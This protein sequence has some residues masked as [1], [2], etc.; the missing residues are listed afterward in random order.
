M[1][2]LIPRWMFILT[3]KWADYFKN[4]WLERGGIKE[5]LL[6]SIPLIFSVSTVTIQHFIDH[7]FFSWYSPEALASSMT[8]GLFQFTLLS[9]FIGTAGYTSTLIAQYYGASKYVRIHSGRM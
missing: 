1:K 7:L 4:R 5:L 6:I 8:A 9:L 3:I 2:F